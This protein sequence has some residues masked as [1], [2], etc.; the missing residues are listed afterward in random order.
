MIR[1]IVTFYCYFF[2]FLECL[3][4]EN[5]HKIDPKLA[6]PLLFYV[7]TFIVTFLCLWNVYF[8]KMYTHSIPN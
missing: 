8:Q 7:I 5:L 4:L 3:F 2:V 1:F 6:S